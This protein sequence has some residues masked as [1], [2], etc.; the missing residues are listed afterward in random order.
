MIAGVI[1]ST[2]TPRSWDQAT[3]LR[4]TS[5]AVS[6]G[7]AVPGLDADDA[8]AGID[9]GAPGHVTTMAVRG[10]GHL[11]STIN[12]A[13]P[14]RGDS[15]GMDSVGH[16]KPSRR[17]AGPPDSSTPPREAFPDPQLKQIHRTDPANVPGHHT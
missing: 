12:R 15:V 2:V 11:S 9:H 16:R 3:A 5:M 4:T 13:S 10:M 14:G 7:L 17:G 1:C 6:S 8:G